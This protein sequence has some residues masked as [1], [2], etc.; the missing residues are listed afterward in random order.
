MSCST[1]RPGYVITTR[2]C[3]VIAIKATKATS[4][5]A[6]HCDR[7]VLTF[8]LGCDGSLRLAVT[9]RARR[10]R[11]SV[12]SRYRAVNRRSRNRLGPDRAVNR[13]EIG[14]VQVK[15]GNPGGG[16]VYQKGTHPP[17]RF[18]GRGG[19][20]TGHEIRSLGPEVGRGQNDPVPSRI[21]VRLD[22]TGWIG[23][24][25]PQGRSCRAVLK[26]RPPE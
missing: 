10:P 13:G 23:D 18:P 16:G 9:S 3:R 22:L 4:H 12:G 26:F 6:S 19:V 5:L 7:A 20:R 21:M 14:W 11:V 1:I 8:R 15:G 17:P 25:V 2:S 24:G